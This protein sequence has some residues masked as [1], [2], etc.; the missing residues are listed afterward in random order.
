MF[1]FFYELVV[2]DKMIKLECIGYFQIK[3][4]YLGNKEKDYKV[5]V[6]FYYMESYGLR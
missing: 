1:Q 6:S 4:Q 5:E 3:Q 2:I